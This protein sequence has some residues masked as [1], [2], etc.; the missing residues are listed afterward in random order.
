MVRL[1][2]AVML[3]MRFSQL[4]SLLMVTPRYLLSF[5]TSSIWV[6]RRAARFVSNNFQDREP[7]AVTSIISNLKWESLEQR[8]AKA[9]SVLMYKIPMV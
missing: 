1:A 2:L 9:R 8:R 5:V 6:Q 3:L 4:R 7:G